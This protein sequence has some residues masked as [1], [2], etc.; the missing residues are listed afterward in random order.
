[1]VW[2]ANLEPWRRTSPHEAGK[3]HAGSVSY[4]NGNR[5]QGRWPG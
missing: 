1:M 3:P 5:N 4:G 2:K